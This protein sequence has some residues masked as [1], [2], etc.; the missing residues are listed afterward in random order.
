MKCCRHLIS[1]EPLD[2]IMKLTFDT[3]YFRPYIEVLIN[4]CDGY[5]KYC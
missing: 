2:I 5:V 4:F 3:Q 1:K